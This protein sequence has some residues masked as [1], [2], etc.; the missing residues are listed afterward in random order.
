MEVG[1]RAPYN[2]PTNTLRAYPFTGN[3]VG[4]TDDRSMSHFDVE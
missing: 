2:R 1:D 4:G 3:I